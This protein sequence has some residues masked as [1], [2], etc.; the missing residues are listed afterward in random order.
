MNENL[1]EPTPRPI[2]LRDFVQVVFG[3]FAHD[4]SRDGR[5]QDEEIRRMIELNGLV[6]FDPDMLDLN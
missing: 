5:Q 6:A 2:P 4:R 1:L 3:F